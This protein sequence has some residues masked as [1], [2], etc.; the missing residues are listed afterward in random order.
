[1]HPNHS[2]STVITLCFK[3]RLTARVAPQARAW[4]YGV[5]S[6]GSCGDL[7]D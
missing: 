5:S 6:C 3:A 4:A 2:T 1:M 7:T